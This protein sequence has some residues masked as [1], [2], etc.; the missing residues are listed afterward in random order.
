MK[1]CI[2][3]FVSFNSGFVAVRPCIS[4]LSMIWAFLVAFCESLSLLSGFDRLGGF[5]E[6]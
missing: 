5:V 2:F 1:L 3:F 6:W 4:W